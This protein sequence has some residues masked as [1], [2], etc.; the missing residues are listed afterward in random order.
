[1]AC[2][3]VKIG[4]IEA[5]VCGD[6]ELSDKDKET[7]LNLLKEQK[8]EKTTYLNSIQRD[9]DQLRSLFLSLLLKQAH[10]ESLARPVAK[11]WIF[12]KRSLNVGGLEKIVDFIGL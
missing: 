5:I 3:H 2:K 9:E 6:G 7:M 8:D 10:F 12:G 4:E 11:D 1:M